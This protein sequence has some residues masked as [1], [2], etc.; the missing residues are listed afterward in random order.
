MDCLNLGNRGGGGGASIFEPQKKKKRSRGASKRDL[1]GHEFERIFELNPLNLC[2]HERGGE[3]AL[4][5]SKQQ[6]QQIT[7]QMRG[8]RQTVFINPKKVAKPRLSGVAQVIPRGGLADLAI[9][10]HFQ[11]HL[12]GPCTILAVYYRE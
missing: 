8:E 1:G 3:K 7:R 9:Q 6:E 2:A 12:Q 4:K 11:P 10:G 5:A